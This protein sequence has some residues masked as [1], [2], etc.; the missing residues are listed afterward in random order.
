MGRPKQFDRD[1]ALSRAVELFRER[2]YEGASTDDLLRAM[3]IGRQSLYDTFGDK[4]TLYME[5]LSR[6]HEIAR[7][8]FTSEI[9][10]A[11]APLEAIERMLLEVADEPPVERAR[12]CL[13]VNATTERAPL[14][15]EVARLVRENRRMCERSFE[16]A[17]RAAQA[18]GSLPRGLDASAASELLFTTLQG[19]RVTA[20]AGASPA[21]LR[22]VA[23]LAI[24]GLRAPPPRARR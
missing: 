13:L 9:V 18:E 17:V 24:E 4:H 8:R 10:R 12:G 19:L 6:Y 14:D 21:T 20:K 7:E 5:A 22:A 15:P 23:K 3:G 11:E 1:E 2:G 16:H